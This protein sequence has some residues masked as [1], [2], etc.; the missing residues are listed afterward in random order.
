MSKAKGKMGA[1]AKAGRK[2]TDGNS[3]ERLCVCCALLVPLFFEQ[4]FSM[5]LSPQLDKI[6]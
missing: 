2:Q 6:A 5:I 4:F 1:K 3:S